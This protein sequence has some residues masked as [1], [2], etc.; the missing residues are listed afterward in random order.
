MQSDYKKKLWKAIQLSIS[1]VAMVIVGYKVSQPSLSVPTIS[2]NTS[3]VALL[4]VILLILMVFNWWL[5]AK[6]WQLLVSRFEK[7]SGSEALMDVMTGLVWSWVIPFTVGDVLARV[8]GYAERTKA[9]KSVVYNRISA[10]V[11]AG[12]FGLVGFFI[13]MKWIEPA[14]VIGWAGG[15]FVIG[16]FVLF[17]YAP[18]WM[19]QLVLLSMVR[20]IIMA[21]QL[22]LL[23]MLVTEDVS[24]MWLFAGIGWIFFFRSFIPG[25]WGALG[26]RELSALVF[27][28]CC[29]PASS[30]LFTT[31]SLW[32]INLV[33]PSVLTV[34]YQLYSQ[35]KFSLDA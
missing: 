22:L 29:I 11:I 26:V 6:K 4:G 12:I 9:V 23:L 31:L 3:G 35:T 7:V 8:Q 14:L 27:F 17:F 18:R 1:V 34:M 10:G 28:E 20:Y 24:I 13:F 33:L 21:I 25:I 32:L 15:L 16:L 30:I 2:I 19:Y 5:E